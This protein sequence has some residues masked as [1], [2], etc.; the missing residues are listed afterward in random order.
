MSSGQ[1]SLSAK[2]S[3]GLKPNYIVN[4][5]GNA[6]PLAVSLFVV[7]IYI[8]HIGA[9]R[10]GIMSLVWILLGYFGF[11]DFGLSRASANALSRI[12]SADAAERVPVLITALYLNAAL[13]VLAGLFMYAAGSLMSSHM[14]AMSGSLHDEFAAALPWMACMLPLSMIAGVGTGAIESREQFLVSNV[15]TTL[16]GVLGQVLPICFALLIGP[17]LTV[18]VPAALLARLIST[19]GV[20]AY[21]ARAERPINLRHFDRSRVRTLLGYGA[22]VSV[23]GLISPMLET[24]DQMLVGALLGPASLAH[25]TV[26]MSL[27]T[28]SQIIASALAKTLF[29]RLSRLERSEAEQLTLRAA[30]TLSFGFAAV[31]APA[32]ILAGPFLTLWLG[33][34]FARP[35]TPVAIILLFG[36]WTNGIAF[37]PFA[38]LQSQGR[39]DLTAKIHLCEI[40]PFLGSVWLLTASFGLAGAALAW[41]LRV[42]VDL[43]IMLWAG[44]LFRSPVGSIGL[45][46]AL[47]GASCAVAWIAHPTGLFSLLVACIVGAA[48]V[49]TALVIDKEARGSAQVLLRRLTAHRAWLVLRRIVSS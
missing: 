10:Y 22:W 4:L 49:A 41:T 17:S 21:V 20:L 1:S 26:P 30:V 29:P 23:T 39:P 7:P 38:F 40:L 46:A 28:R 47:V 25:Y 45:S 24:F 18:V 5:I 42:S 3:R 34:E 27:T 13:G 31:C 48:I 2:Q 12:A 43:V 6:L 15:F 37:I 19:V 11:L 32:V 36:A 44:R 16:G 33:A 35:A 9:D 14:S 8:H